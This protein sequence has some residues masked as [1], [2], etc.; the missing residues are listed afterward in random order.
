MKKKTL[1]MILALFVF[2]GIVTFLM[3]FLEKRFGP[4][5]SD[6]EYKINDICTLR[7]SSAYAIAVGCS[8]F[9]KG[10]DP[11]IIKIGWNSNYVVAVTHPV[12]KRKYPDS[13]ENTYMVP[14][15][16]LTYW[17]ILD[18]NKKV[19]YGPINSEEEFNSKKIDLKIEDINLVKPDDL[20]NSLK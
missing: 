14:D 13:S 20:V 19:N 2:L 7:R 12:T 6:Y 8:G 10:I 4:G 5:L 18:L 1:L 11:V 17:W 3:F 9:E 15:E 16:S